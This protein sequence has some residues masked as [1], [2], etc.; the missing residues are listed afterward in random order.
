[1]PERRFSKLI[2]MA[3]TGAALALS[4]CKKPDDGAS[5][6]GTTEEGAGE[7]KNAVRVKQEIAGER[8]SLS[9][10][11]AGK[12]ESFQGSALLVMA[13]ASN[14]ND[15]KFE[16]SRLNIRCPASWGGEKNARWQ[17][18]IDLPFEVA[19]DSA[20]DNRGTM[21]VEVDD[22]KF[23]ATQFSRSSFN[24]LP[25]QAEA[26]RDA[27]LGGTSITFSIKT[28]DGK[29]GSS[30]SGLTGTDE[31]KQYFAENC[32]LQAGASTSAKTE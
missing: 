1:M 6:Q 10:K 3:L 4:A 25:E 32:G 26:F 13:D 23:D 8:W 31:V 16:K 22:K 17:A 28:I 15:M 14:D 9:P 20:P 11:E 29:S 2:L 21:T 19:Y 5:R 30:T 18:S 27:V 12:E 7:D 24:I